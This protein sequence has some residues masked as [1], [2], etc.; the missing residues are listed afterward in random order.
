MARKFTTLSLLLVTF[1]ASANIHAEEAQNEYPDPTRFEKAIQKFEEQDK[2][3]FPPA[4]AIVCIG[5]SS[6]RGWHKDIAQDLSPLTVIPRGFGG[7][8]MNDVLHYTDRAVLAYKPRAIL[9]Y[10]G[11]N[12][13]AQK[14]TPQKIT[15]TF[16]TFVEK[17]HT[18]LPECRIY[19]I[20]IKPS[21]KRWDIWPKMQDANDRIAQACDKDKRLTYIDVA[22]GMIGED[23]TP[24]PHIFKKDNLHMV[25]SGYEIWRDAVRP[26]LIE[27]ELA[28]ESK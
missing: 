2:E 13:V 25:R 4:N 7:S 18:E 1:F 15:D 21:I 11:D 9:L 26:V 6:M 28:H 12:D 24:H 3:Q 27:N 16:L 14:I 10:E 22:T 20:S 19:F 17:V 23:G 5:S 8:N